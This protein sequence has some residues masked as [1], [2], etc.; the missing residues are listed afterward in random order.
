LGLARLSRR[1]CC[2]SWMH[3]ADDARHVRCKRW[4][5]AGPPARIRAA[6][7]AVRVHRCT[8]TQRSVQ[9]RSVR[10]HCDAAHAAGRERDYAGA[11]EAWCMPS[12]SGGWGV[13]IALGGAPRC[14][15]AVRARALLA[16]KCSMNSKSSSKPC[17]QAR[18]IAP[19][20]VHAP[21]RA[22]LGRASACTAGLHTRLLATRARKC[23]AR[24]RP[25]AP[26]AR[27]L[28]VLRGARAARGARRGA[29][30]GR[31]GARGAQE[32]ARNERI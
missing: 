20:R 16:G 8:A 29:P 28:R 9:R 17:D 24:M 12:A 26:R 31:R 10:V 7:S 18:C 11:R 13:R 30:A 27:Q 23:V 22:W 25:W 21:L 19:Q 32:G 4:R 1:A 14:V 15:K 6:L 2:A 3:T 5:D